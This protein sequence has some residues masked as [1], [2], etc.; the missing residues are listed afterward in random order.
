MGVLDRDIRI[1]R[2]DGESSFSETHDD[3]RVAD[4]CEGAVGG[5]RRRQRPGLD[6]RRQ[7]LEGGERRDHERRRHRER[8]RTSRASSRRARRAARRTSRSTRIAPATSR[9]TSRARRTSARRGSRSTSGLP[10]DA[11]VRSIYEYPGKANVVFAGTERHLFVSHDS[12]A[13][14][15]QLAGESADDAL[16][17]H[18]RPSAHEGSRPRARTAAASGFST[19]R[20]RSPSGRR[21]SRRSRSYLFAGAARDAACSTGKTSRTS[22]RACTPPRIPADG[23][24]FTYSSRR[25]PRRRCGSSC[26]ARTAK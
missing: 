25:S 22:R 12:G 14:W 18:R 16:R 4:R 13:H 21:R 20:R 3:R 5:H 1:S 17:R 10:G 7:D 6:R 2:N 15:T 23:A 26:A 19:T 11:S 9:R 24:T 8:Q